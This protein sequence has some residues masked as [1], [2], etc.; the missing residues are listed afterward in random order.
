[1]PC[2][3]APLDPCQSVTRIGGVVCWHGTDCC[4]GCCAGRSPGPRRYPGSRWSSTTRRRYVSS[5]LLLPVY[6]THP[7]SLPS[8]EACYSQIGSH[9]NM[10]G[11]G[12]R[13][14]VNQ[15]CSAR[16]PLLVGRFAHASFKLMTTCILYRLLALSGRLHQRHGGGGTWHRRVGPVA[17][18]AVLAGQGAPGGHNRGV[19]R[20]Q[21]HNQRNRANQLHHPPV[22]HRVS[23]RLACAS[24]CMGTG[25]KVVARA[26]PGLRRHSSFFGNRASTWLKRPH[27]RAVEQGLQR[28]SASCC[29]PPCSLWIKKQPAAHS[30]THRP[31]P[32]LTAT[33]AGPCART[34]C[35][36]AVWRSWDP[37]AASCR[38]CVSRVPPCWD[39][40][41]PVR[42]ILALRCVVQG[43]VMLVPRG[44]KCPIPFVQVLPVLNSNFHA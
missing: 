21:H 2:S 41:M 17:R 37:W 6:L 35:P 30:L 26:T 14:H 1:M 39:A 19:R 29:N 27:G 8:Y 31:V 9:G 38:W 12:H 42:C 10:R 44:A 43:N 20:H 18:Q 16:R 5:R 22:Q 40:C 25:G 32:H 34:S 3:A 28:L 15:S 13:R 11:H 36:P 33:A 7:G 23:S 24:T 4:C